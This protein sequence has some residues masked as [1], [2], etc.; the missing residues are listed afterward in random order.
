MK[1]LDQKDEIKAGRS[2]CGILISVLDFVAPGLVGLDE[3]LMGC[4]DV[5]HRVKDSGV[6]KVSFICWQM[7]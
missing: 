3:G 5:D 6:L 7:I 2:I 4:Q 1:Y